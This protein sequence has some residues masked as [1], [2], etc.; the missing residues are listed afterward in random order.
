VK[1]HKYNFWTEDECLFLVYGVKCFGASDWIDWCKITTNFRDRLNHRTTN[2]CSNKY[3]LLKLRNHLKK[4]E[5]L[6]EKH[7]QLI[8]EFSKNKIHYGTVFRYFRNLK[9]VD[10]SRSRISNENRIEFQDTSFTQKMIE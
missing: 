3:R 7:W 2:D 6:V 4:Y 1:K 8:C 9:A 10:S 5:A